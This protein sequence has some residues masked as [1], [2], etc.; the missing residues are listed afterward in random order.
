MQL[1][2]LFFNTSL[3]KPIHF[4]ERLDLQQNLMHDKNLSYSLAWTIFPDSWSSANHA[5]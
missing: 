5:P 2:I 4:V 1:D 3:I